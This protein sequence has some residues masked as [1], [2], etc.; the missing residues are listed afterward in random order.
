MHPTALPMNCAHM[1]WGISLRSD[2]HRTQFWRVYTNI[3]IKALIARLDCGK[4]PPQ[5]AF[6]P[7]WHSYCTVALQP[8]LWIVH[9]WNGVSSYSVTPTQRHPAHRVHASGAACIQ[10]SHVELPHLVLSG[11]FG[12]HCKPSTV[13]ALFARSFSKMGL[14]HSLDQ[15]H[16]VPVWSKN[17]TVHKP[18]YFFMWWNLKS[19]IQ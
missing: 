17:G 6:Y 2:T 1:I 18:N 11:A 14:A 8:Y 19:Q 9:P 10:R 12:Q 13:T 16:K 5:S 4:S 3:S 7:Y 15:G